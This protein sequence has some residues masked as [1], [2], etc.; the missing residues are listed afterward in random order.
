[1]TCAQQ[2]TCASTHSFKYS[3]TSRRTF[4]SNFSNLP[5][6]PPLPPPPPL[7]LLLVLV[8]VVG[9]PLKVL[10]SGAGGTC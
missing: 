4:A 3:F 2:R 9:K 5:P 6:L 10:S 7:P 1:V 8:V